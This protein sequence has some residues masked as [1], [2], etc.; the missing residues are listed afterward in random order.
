MEKQK[1]VVGWPDGGNVASL[2]AQ[3][4][5]G[6]QAFEMLHPN[7]DYEVVQYS[8][9]SGLYVQENRNR[10][11][12]ALLEE[13]ADWLLQLDGDESFQPY[14]L[15]QL[16]QTAD[17]VERPIVVGLYTNLG[18]IDD[19]T[20][21]I[22]LINCIYKEAED[23]RYTAVDPPEDL[24]PFE[25]AAAGTGVMLCHRSVFEKLEYPWFWV[26]L[27]ENEDGSTQM[28]NEDLGFCRAARV[29]GFPIW[30]N[31]LAEVVHWK[32]LPLVPSTVRQYLRET[33][34]V[35]SDMASSVAE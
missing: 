21:A 16:M 12:K 6:F 23:G 25:V 10:L 1:V 33:E 29:A 22:T 18:G 3:S 13:G 2:F 5:L 35:F 30:C 19:R 32:S 15:R 26:D 4:L 14:L 28:M 24:Q 27:Y 9:R 8:A 7:D 34:R 31:P 20:G 11:V 17:S